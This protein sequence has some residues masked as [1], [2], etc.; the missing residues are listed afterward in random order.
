MFCVKQKRAELSWSA[1]KKKKRKQVSKQATKET[2]Q[3][4]K[5]I[6]FLCCNKLCSLIHNK[7]RTSSTLYFQMTLFVRQHCFLFIFFAC[8]KFMFIAF[9][10]FVDFYIYIYIYFNLGRF[11]VPCIIICLQDW[12][13]FRILYSCLKF[14]FVVLVE[15]KYIEFLFEIYVCSLGGVS[16]PCIFVC[17]L[18]G[19]SVPCIYV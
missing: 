1:L 7:T 14:M 15:F 11:S 8:F 19:A 6:I 4:P 10:P 5:T 18:G 3:T 17:S 12:W 16:V 9:A 2:E 13:S